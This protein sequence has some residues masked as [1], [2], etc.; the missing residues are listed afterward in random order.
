MTFNPPCYRL[1]QGYTSLLKYYKLDLNNFKISFFFRLSKKNSFY[2]K[3]TL[4]TPKYD[5]FN[6]IFCSVYYKVRLTN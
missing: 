2:M 5:F 6:V 3:M 1:Y 4:N